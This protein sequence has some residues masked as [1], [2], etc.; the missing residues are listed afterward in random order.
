MT[1]RS[2]PTY[3]EIV[4]SEAHDL[5]ESII[6][7]KSEIA[8]L[9]RQ[10]GITDR[11][12]DTALRN[13]NDHQK[14]V[15]EAQF[16]LL[17]KKTTKE[18][19]RKRLDELAKSIDEE[20]IRISDFVENV[21]QAELKMDEKTTATITV[22][23]ERKELKREQGID[24]DSSI[25]NALQQLDNSDPIAYTKKLIDFINKYKIYLSKPLQNSLDDEITTLKSNLDYHRDTK[26]KTNALTLC[27]ISSESIKQSFIAMALPNIKKLIDES[28]KQ[29]L[30]LL[31]NYQIGKDAS[32]A[33]SKKRV[34][35]LL[36]DKSYET[37]QEGTAPPNR[38]AREAFLEHLKKVL[39]DKKHGDQS[40]TL[41]MKDLLDEYGIEL[42]QAAIK[43]EHQSE[44][45]RNAVFLQSA[46]NY[47]GKKWNQRLV[48][49][50]GGPSASG[51]TFNAEA[52]VNDVSAK[53]M[54]KDQASDDKSENIVVSVDGAVEREV[55][56][57]RQLTLQAAL[58][59][60]YKGIEDLNDKTEKITKSN[61]TVKGSTGKHLLIKEKIFDAVAQTQNLSLAIPDTFTS[62][63]MKDE[64]GTFAS[65][66]HTKQVYSKI[67]PKKNSTAKARFRNAVKRMGNSRAW[68]DFTNT[69]K[70]ITK[71][72]INNRNIGCESKKYVG[73][74]FWYGKQR[75]ATARANYIAAQRKAGKP[76][77]T[78]DALHD[79]IYLRKE[80]NKDYNWVDCPPDYAGTDTVVR[81]THRQYEAWQSYR[82][83]QV[84]SGKEYDDL[85]IW[86]KNGTTKYP[87]V[88]DTVTT[89][90][91]IENPTSFDIAAK[92]DLDI[93]RYG[94]P[95]KPSNM[96]R[97]MRCAIARLRMMYAIDCKFRPPE[98][99]Y[100]AVMPNKTQQL[101]D[102]L[103]SFYT[104][105][106]DNI[107]L[108]DIEYFNSDITK[109]KRM[110]NSF[111]EEAYLH[112][113]AIYDE[114]VTSQ[115]IPEATLRNVTHVIGST[116]HEQSNYVENLQQLSTTDPKTGKPHVI[117]KLEQEEKNVY[118]ADKF[119]YALRDEKTIP[120]AIDNFFEIFKNL[121]PDDKATL[122]NTIAKEFK[123]LDISAFSKQYAI[124][125][126]EKNNEGA[127]LDA[128]DA[129]KEAIPNIINEL[130]RKTTPDDLNKWLAIMDAMPLDAHGNNLFYRPIPTLNSDNPSSQEIQ[131]ALPRD[132]NQY[133]YISRKTGGAQDSGPL[134][135][136]HFCCYATSDG[137]I[138][139]QRVMIKRETKFSKNIIES[140]AGALKSLL[141]NQENDY[142]ARTFLVHD[143]AARA[144]GANNYIVSVAFDNFKELTK[145]AGL[146]ERL[147]RAG[148]KNKEA[149]NELNE[150]I[151]KLRDSD[152]YQGG[153]EEGLIACYFTGD[154]DLHT[155]NY[156]MVGQ[157]KIA[158]IDHAGAML[159]LEDEIHPHR[160]G[161]FTILDRVMRLEGPEPTPHTHEY[162]SYLRVSK[163]MGDAIA[164][165]TSRISQ[166]DINKVISDQLDNAA[167][168]YKDDLATLKKFG[169]RIGVK[170]ELK[171]DAKQITEDIQVYLQKKM[172]SRLLSLRQF[173][174]EIQLSE[175]FDIDK[176][177]KVYVSDP[178]ALRKFILDNPNFCKEAEHHFRRK[179]KSKPDKS[180]S[181]YVFHKKWLRTMFG[182]LRGESDQLEALLK[183]ETKNT[184]S[185]KEPLGIRSLLLSDLDESNIQVRADNFASRLRIVRLMLKDE[186]PHPLPDHLK[187]LIEEL[188]SA[189][190]DKTNKHLVQL[191]DRAYSTI[192]QSFDALDTTLAKLKLYEIFTQ[193]HQGKNILQNEFNS[194]NQD[195]DKQFTDLIGRKL[196]GFT[197]NKCAY[198]KTVIS[199]AKLIQN[200]TSAAQHD[201]EL[202]STTKELLA[203]IT[204]V[205]NTLDQIRKLSAST[206]PDRKEIDTTAEA[207]AKSVTALNTAQSNEQQAFLAKVHT[208]DLKANENALQTATV[209]FNQ[210]RSTPNKLA[211]DEAPKSSLT[212]AK[213]DEKPYIAKSESETSAVIM[214]NPWKEEEKN[215]PDHASSGCVIFKEGANT[216]IVDFEDPKISI[217]R[218]LAEELISYMDNA[219]DLQK[220]QTLQDHIQKHYVD[221]IQSLYPPQLVSSANLHDYLKYSLASKP[222]FKFTHLPKGFGGVFDIS[223]TKLSERLYMKKIHPMRSDPNLIAWAHIWFSTLLAKPDVSIKDIRI[224]SAHG[225]SE[226]TRILATYAA[227][228]GADL[229]KADKTGYG[230]SPTPQEVLALKD[231]LENPNNDLHGKVMNL[232]PADYQQ[233]KKELTTIKT[234][235]FS[236]TDMW[237]DKTRNSVQ[238][239]KD[240]DK[241]DP[242]ITLSKLKQDK[243]RLDGFKLT[244]PAAVQLN[245]LLEEKIKAFED[246]LKPQRNLDS[247]YDKK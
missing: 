10:K 28:H 188:E 88:L 203:S 144:V 215:H 15:D 80:N 238:S 56:Q 11:D 68:Y 27:R 176:N 137:K 141:V 44:N 81:L 31:D 48:L 166:T 156:G 145:V 124:Y 33:E 29:W 132:I 234:N 206:V 2:E 87:P 247:K 98:S 76:A 53:H 146:K 207:I 168:L 189:L 140:M 142:T 201:A 111:A 185:Q 54:A 219:S 240:D 151:R 91:I 198:T 41:Q 127:R 19:R 4:N 35:T 125:R 57:I 122:L 154:F 51:K 26:D 225:N 239:I 172:Y 123:P 95:N 130:K 133:R 233:Q 120:L 8:Q 217:A 23:S 75:S 66:K 169:E 173:G 117:A 30:E 205:N 213:T 126:D 210:H 46:K 171:G 21:Q 155:D 110:L 231:I 161:L 78:I 60:G 165:Y 162:R 209:F 187:K 62:D 52:I 212:H 74:W 227:Y 147:R 178:D 211:A 208:L 218:L 174:A 199:T 131:D 13:L 24:E 121:S 241:A 94:D 9:C 116:Q 93:L 32:P 1:K 61:I 73:T 197:I 16:D 136:W 158:N 186:K 163:R 100:D 96:L 193:I 12:A 244:K 192:I 85:D 119:F 230:F 214:A 99:K 40:H 226:F 129:M 67:V 204:T 63:L 92:N 18:L 49:W 182:F 39:S 82:S 5:R 143:P 79:L 221:R 223:L 90:L 89:G 25:F 235:F 148:T 101:I 22:S 149:Y 59:L 139:T 181:G 55:S 216:R 135:G 45:F 232:L 72:T 138:H 105:V 113:K 160:H 20:L 109:I 112:S 83:G 6:N 86:I 50:V 190:Q 228:K 7:K 70:T 97:Y 103:D 245:Q 102:K 34:I 17:T 36:G 164:N 38:T 170:K 43:E 157:S 179:F 153:F 108:D 14:T 106:S 200:L 184:L 64:M 152:E 167:E 159:E 42:Y 69:K 195:K 180:L 115:R 134:G 202:R 104:Y 65:E 246:K 128:K 107:D 222:E 77:I 183:E 220:L 236:E 242:S 194:I 3:E 229:K 243:R 150:K 114:L 84:H 118:L 191:C 71:V 47:P 237:I 175:C 58:V 177:N 224:D 196:A 37:L